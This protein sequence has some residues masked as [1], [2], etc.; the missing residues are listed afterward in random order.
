MKDR[1]SSYIIDSKIYKWHTES[2]KSIEGQL[3]FFDE[4]DAAY[5]ESSREPSAEEVITAKR[6]K[7]KRTAEYRPERFPGRNTSAIQCF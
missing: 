7:K 3:S 6:A 4:A 1:E 2:L 5:D